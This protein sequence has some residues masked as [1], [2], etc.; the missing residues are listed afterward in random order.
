MSPILGVWA[1]AQQ[2][3][4]V[5][6]SSYESI[7]TVTVGSGGSSSVTFSSI[8]STYKHLQIR[9]ISRTSGSAGGYV[10]MQ[11]N[12]DTGSN[13]TRHQLWGDGSSVQAYGAG[14]AT[15][16]VV[17]YQTLSTSLSNT[18]ASVIV[19]ILDYTNSNKYK[20]YRVLNGY[21][22]NGAGGYVFFMSSA[23]LSTSAI[24]SI[25][26]YPEASQNFGQ[27]TQ[28]ALYGIKGA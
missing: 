3:A 10:Y 20:T 7:S 28:F 9:A 14:A 4:F 21:D 25:T 2:S 17:A 8:P 18:F 24:N 27:Y 15:Q 26:L 22:V 16:A 6:T 23:W 1:S 12:G 5:V 13:Y 19:D 11:Y